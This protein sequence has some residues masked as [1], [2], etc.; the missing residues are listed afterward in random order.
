V[1][2]STES[3]ANSFTVRTVHLESGSLD[4]TRLDLTPNEQGER[5]CGLFAEFLGSQ[6]Q[7]FRAPIPF[8]TQHSLEME[9]AAAPLGAALVTIY[10]EGEPVLM[11]VLLSGISQEN[12]L[13]MLFSLRRAVLEP[14]L[15]ERAAALS[16]APERPLLFTVLFP[17]HAELVPLVNLLT[18]ALASFYFRVMIMLQVEAMGGDEDAPVQ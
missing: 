14:M 13:T 10:N 7:E 3:S 5:I 4:L 17:G 18:S 8:L 12:D 15:G 2:P 1:T 11:G 6:P 16:D 9:W